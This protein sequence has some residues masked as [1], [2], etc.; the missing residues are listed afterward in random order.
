MKK[1]KEAISKLGFIDE[2]ET[3]L[4]KEYIKS[5]KE[6][7]FK[8]LV[9][10]L[11]LVDETLMK[12][13]TKLQECV[14]EIKNCKNCSNLLECK[15]EVEGF[16]YTPYVDGKGLT[17]S[18]IACKYKQEEIKNEKYQENVYYF[19]IPKEIKEARM[20]KIYISDKNRIEVI[21]WLKEFID[22]YL[23]DENKK[24]LY[25][26]GNFGGG[27]TYL[28]AAAFNELARRG[29]QVAIIYWSELLRDL[30]A[31]FGD[32]FAEKYDYIKRI[33][34]LLIDDIGAENTTPW[35]RDEILG[36]LLQY[37]M[38]EKLTT[39]FT[40]NL[41]LEELEIHFSNTD[42]KTDKLKARRII[43]RIKQLSTEMKMISKNNRK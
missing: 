13:T 24:G 1:I 18:Y 33:P 3:S 15:N 30:K 19:D 34:L 23:K 5:L 21:S 39:F 26:Y 17:F 37:R 29:K 27:K 36:P 14:K 8:S 7:D 38:E 28:I 42:Y 6:A 25:L 9:E 40:S 35:S 31:S 2:I 20:S 43:E 16:V 10:K 41:S 4:K 22:R 12:Y 11:P 32:D